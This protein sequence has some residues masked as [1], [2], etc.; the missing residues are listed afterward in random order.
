MAKKIIY[1]EEARKALKNGVDAVANAVKIT[2]GP[3][4][5]NVVYDKG[6]GGPIISNDGVSIARHDVHYVITEFGIAYL[7][8]KS[9]RERALALIDVAHP[10]FKPWLFE[11]GK[12]LGYIPKDQILKNL[13][14]Y[15]I[16][17]ERTIILKNGKTILLRPA[18]TT[19]A[20][21]IQDLFHELPS[22]DVY[23][24]FFHD[25]RGLSSAENQRLC[26]TNPDNEMAFIAIEGARE[27][28]VIVGHACYFIDHSTNL[29]ETAFIVHPE[30]QG[31]GLG[32]VMQTRLKEHAIS[33][34]I[35]GFTAEILSQNQKMIKL[36]QRCSENISI[37]KDEDCI[38]ITMLF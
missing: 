27:N 22:N 28:D 23:T 6:Y 29:A 7:H 38:H 34:N 18:I 31:T 14:A 12:R 24:R 15:A 16:E 1:N 17:E 37:E 8:G 21:E 9:I 36:A 25:L 4:G 33:K 19:D 2:I 20:E 26:N 35:K 5:R 13:R 11:E 30:W 32:T 3:K 10:K